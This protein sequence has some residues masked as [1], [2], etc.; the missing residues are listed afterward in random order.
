VQLA[1]R[2]ARYPGLPLLWFR[3]SLRSSRLRY[4]ATRDA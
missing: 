4:R 1:A 2:V 3:M